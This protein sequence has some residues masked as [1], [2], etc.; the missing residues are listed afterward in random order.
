MKATVTWKGNM[1]FTGRGPSGHTVNMDAPPSAGGQ[2][3]SAR[4]ME[5]LL[6]ALGGCTAMDVISILKKKRKTVTFLEIYLDADQDQDYPK[7]LNSVL[8]TYKLIGEDLDAESVRRAIELSEKKYCSVAA[9]LGFPV[10]ISWNM[11]VGE[12][13]PHKNNSVREK[14]RK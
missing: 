12:K 10:K 1:L 4:P 9:T 2:D 5:I 11:E 14:P 8:I 13:L 6:L 7:K 3:S